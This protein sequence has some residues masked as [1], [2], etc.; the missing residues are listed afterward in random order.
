MKGA[1]YYEAM[2][3]VILSHVMLFSHVQISSFRAKAHL[4]FY[5]INENSCHKQVGEIR[6]P[7]FT[8]LSLSK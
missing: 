1:I 4:V 8:D 6:E 5:I 2:A 7:S 3:M